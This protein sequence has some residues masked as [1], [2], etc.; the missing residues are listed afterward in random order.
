[1][2]PRGEGRRTGATTRAACCRSPGRQRRARRCRLPLFRQPRAR[3]FRRHRP[4]RRTDAQ[5]ARQAAAAATARL[6]SPRV[7]DLFL[8]N[9]GVDRGFGGEQRRHDLRRD[10]A[11]HAG[12]GRERSPA[13]RATRSSRSRASSP[14]NAE[15]TKGR[16]M[17]ILGA[18]MN[19]WYHMDMNYRGIINML[20]MC[21][22]VG[23][24]GGGWAHYVGPG[25]AAAAD[26]L[27]AARLRARL[28]RPPRQHELDVVLLRPHRPVALRDARRRRKSSRPRR[29]R[30]HGTER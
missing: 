23:Q 26:R 27:G 28:G 24:S 11:L 10:R 7:Y 22:C 25:K 17:V 9:Y 14:R 12:L 30:A 19:H 4:S 21:G 18:G 8:A 15:K 20:V 3:P 2:E 29:R 16:S 13:S 1:M 6:W 5:G